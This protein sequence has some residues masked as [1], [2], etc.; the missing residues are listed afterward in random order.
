MYERSP[1][2]LSTQIL[3]CLPHAKNLIDLYCPALLGF[4]PYDVTQRLIAHQPEQ[5]YD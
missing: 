3:K 4:L 2:S 1:I 5:G